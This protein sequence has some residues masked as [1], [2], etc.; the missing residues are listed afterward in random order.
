MRAWLVR[1]GRS[2]EREAL[3]LEQGLAVIGWDE[4]PDLSGSR[5]R[6]SL[7]E[8]LRRAYPDD[9]TKRFLSWQAQLW[10]FVHS[11]SEGDLVALPLKATPA[12]AIGH[13][14]GNYRYRNDLPSGA[15]HTRPVKWR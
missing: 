13:V 8:A 15:R 7:M 10:A 6:D 9:G 14:T 3:A 2:G 4:L 5:T 1:A 11:I 12:V